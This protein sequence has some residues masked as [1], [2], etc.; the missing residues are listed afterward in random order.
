VKV[1]ANGS[2]I[3]QLSTGADAYFHKGLGKMYIIR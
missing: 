3:K 1:Q 2:E